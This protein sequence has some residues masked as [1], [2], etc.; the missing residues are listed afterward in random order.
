MST[1]DEYLQAY[2]QDVTP[3]LASGLYRAWLAEAD[4]EPVACVVLII[5]DDAPQFAATAP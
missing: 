2:M 4:G 1:S 3:A 5:M